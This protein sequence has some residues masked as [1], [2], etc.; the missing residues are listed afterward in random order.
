MLK[1]FYTEEPFYL[2]GVDI[3]CCIGDYMD[4]RDNDESTFDVDENTVEGFHYIPFE[5]VVLLKTG[6]PI[7]DIEDLVR[8]I[9]HTPHRWI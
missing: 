5:Q 3:P 7:C 2:D 9:T 4:P 8:D 1:E 6:R